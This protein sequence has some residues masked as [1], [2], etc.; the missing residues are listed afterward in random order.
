MKTIED[1]RYFTLMFVVWVMGFGNTIMVIG[2]YD[3]SPLI[4]YTPRYS[5]TQGNPILYSYINQFMV[6]VGNFS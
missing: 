4:T 3:S 5:Y 6:R 1:S 2:L